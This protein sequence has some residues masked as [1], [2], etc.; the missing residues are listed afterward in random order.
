ML[1]HA[2]ALLGLD[3]PTDEA[4]P[5]SSG[6]GEPSVAGWLPLLGLDEPTDDATPSSSGVGEPSVAGWLPLLVELRTYAE[7]AWSERTFLDLLEHLHAGEGLGLPRAMLEQFLA[8][9]GRAVV[10]F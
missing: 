9:D 3:E 2:A 5:S 8:R 7:P 4:R 10:T 6:V 1:A